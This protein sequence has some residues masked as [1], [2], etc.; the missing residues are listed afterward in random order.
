MIRFQ[1]GPIF[2]GNSSDYW[3]PTNWFTLDSQDLDLG[4]SAHYSWTC[5]AQRPPI[6]SLQWAKMA[7]RI[8]LIAITSVVSPHPV[9]SAQDLR[10]LHHSGSGR[11]PD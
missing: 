11:L 8:Y 3:A 6:S 5:R 10:R 4:S 1:P 2:S 9:A 7:M